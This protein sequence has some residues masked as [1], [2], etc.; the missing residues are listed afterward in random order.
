MR[1]KIGV[2]ARVE[3]ERKATIGTRNLQR[4]LYTFG[5]QEMLMVC[6]LS[7]QPQHFLSR[8]GLIADRR[9]R[10]YSGVYF[11]YY[12]QFH[13]QHRSVQFKWPTS[14]YPVST[15]NKINSFPHVNCRENQFGPSPNPSRTHPFCDIP[16]IDQQRLGVVPKGPS[17]P[18]ET[19]VISTVTYQTKSRYGFQWSVFW[20]FEGT[21]KHN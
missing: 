13:S 17:L 11:K 6:L 14:A 21:K 1:R 9:D 19:N 8:S 10:V 5:A 15:I 18:S 3:G 20:C 12:H 16:A 2:H 7:A 4:S